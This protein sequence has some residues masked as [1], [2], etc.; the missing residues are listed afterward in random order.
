MDMM[1][2]GKVL[3][4]Q[5][6]KMDP[7]PVKQFVLWFQ[8]AQQAALPLANAMT[9]AT[10]GRQGKPA[11]R[12]LLLKKV[13]ER[14]FVFFTNYDSRKG[15]ELRENSSAALVFYWAPLARQVRIEG[16]VELLAPSES[17]A[18]FASRPR[19]HQ[20]EAHASPQSQVIR[21]RMHLEKRFQEV[22]RKY[23][24]QPVPRPSHWG[25]YRLVPDRLEF[26]QEGDNRLHDRIC[27]RRNRTGCW[28]MERLAP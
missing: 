14:G 7:D 6:G 16:V 12:I 9:L 21:D 24:G 1:P 23:Q 19:G 8:A 27:Y 11:A 4:L 26:W 2:D 5:S 10:S 28:M 18:Y 22:T 20:I 13:D 15:Q 17:D 25:G 3:P